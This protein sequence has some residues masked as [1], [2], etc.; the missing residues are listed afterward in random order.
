MSRRRICLLLLVTGWCAVAAASDA[1]IIRGQRFSNGPLCGERVGFIADALFY[2]AAAVAVHVQVLDVSSGGAPA[3]AA[4]F[5]I[6]ANDVVD[7][8]GKHVEAFPFRDLWVTHVSS[9]DG[10]VIDGTLIWYGLDL[11]RGI[12]PSP[13]YFGRITLPVFHALTAPGVTALH[14]STDL[15]AADVR[16]NV[17][18]Y[19]AGDVAANA[20]VRVYR[21]ACGADPVDTRTIE[22]GARSVIQL[23]ISPVKQCDLS[24]PVA[25]ITVVV[26]QAS[27]SWVTSLNNAILPG[28]TIGSSRQ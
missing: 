25:Y 24:D 17:G 27:L 3:G 16:M 20:A 8:G 18:I 14:P 11:C 2:N 23:S 13:Y 1:W 15:G 4:E 12:N 9:P 28:V 19:N 6:P 7:L 10:V 5:D 21:H 26:D 22:V